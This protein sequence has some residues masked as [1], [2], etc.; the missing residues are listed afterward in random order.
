MLVLEK[1][2]QGEFSI[3]WGTFNDIKHMRSSPDDSDRLCGR[4]LTVEKRK[5]GMATRGPGHFSSIERSECA[6]VGSFI[7]LSALMKSPTD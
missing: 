6:T 4:V 5:R 1:H 7:Q 2:G 3:V